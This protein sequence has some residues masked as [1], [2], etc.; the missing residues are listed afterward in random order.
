ML[1]DSFRWGNPSLTI[2]SSFI[3]LQSLARTQPS[4]SRIKPP[5]QNLADREP[6][7]MQPAEHPALEQGQARP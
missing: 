7:P 4:H 2:L 1:C 3:V 6:D 5:A